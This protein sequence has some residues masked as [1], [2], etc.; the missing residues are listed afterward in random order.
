MKV[1]TFFEVQDGLRQVQPSSLTQRLRDDQFL[2]VVTA[3]NGRQIALVGDRA[4][5]FFNQ[6]DRRVY[7]TVFTERIDDLREIVFALGPLSRQKLGLHTG[8]ELV[9]C[10]RKTIGEVLFELLP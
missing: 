5:W 2:R 6:L 7:S 8:R 4:S 10:V 1:T 9:N 3:L